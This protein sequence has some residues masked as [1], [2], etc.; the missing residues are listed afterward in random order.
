MVMTSILSL[1]F[2]ALL[3]VFPT[4]SARADDVVVSPALFVALGFGHQA[5]FSIGVDLRATYAFG[6]AWGCTAER[7]SGIGAFAQAQWF[8][9]RG[10][11]LT[12]GLHAGREFDRSGW[13]DFELGWSYTGSMF[14]GGGHGFQIGVLLGSLPFEGTARGN[15]AFGEDTA[16]DA[17]LG[18]GLR[19]PG[20]F[21]SPSCSGY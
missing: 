19:V 12:A 9:A 1:P 18:L 20:P 10:G 14:G 5:T 7:L 17:Q 15:L 2:V 8:L 4:F 13:Y 6:D 11:R 3:L 16:F 21:G